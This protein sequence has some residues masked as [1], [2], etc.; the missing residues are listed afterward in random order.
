VPNKTKIA[1][2]VAIAIGT[3]VA[4]TTYAFAGNVYDS[5]NW[6]PPL[7]GWDVQRPSAMGIYESNAQ[8]TAPRTRGE[9]NPGRQPNVPRKQH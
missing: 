2:C 4:A 5:P 6:A 9:R 8:E 1:L 7:Y 3:A